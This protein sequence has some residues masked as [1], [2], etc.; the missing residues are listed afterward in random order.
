MFG[1]L[2]EKFQ[3]LFHSLAGKTTLTEDGIADAVKQVRLALL[4]ADVNYSVVSQF[5]KKVKE[6]CLGDS[7]LK[8]VKPGQYFTKIIHDELVA[9]MGNQEEPLLLKGS[10]AVI[11]LCGLQGS[12][13]TTQ[14]AK[15]GRYLLEQNK[16]R[17]IMLAACD[18]QRPAAVLQLKKLGEQIGIPV[19]ALEGE[20]DPVKV[21]VKALDEAKQEGFDILIL[22]TAGRLH[23]D[24]ELMEQ[25]QKIKAKTNPC[26]ILFVASCHTGQDAVKTAQEFDQKVSLTGTILTMLDGSA[27]AGAAI[28]IREITGKPLKFEGV[29]EKDLQL[30]NP[31]SMA[32]RILGMGDIIN[33]VRK[34]QEHFNEQEQ[35]ELEKKMMKA[36]FTFGDYLKSMKMMKKMGSFKSILQMIPGMPALD[37]MQVDEKE[38][39]RTEAIVLSMTPSER[40][41]KVELSHSRRKRIAKGCG[42]DVESVNRFVNKFTKMKQFFKDM[43]ALQ[44]QMQKGMGNKEKFLWR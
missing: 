30:F 28:S 32:D 34:S 13:K 25:L 43:P 15:L 23:V 31:H 44:K 8:S 41:G 29:G 42:M 9:L 12:G 38:I 26:E 17:K 11:M 40:E 5:I 2:T 33:L 36:S 27:R 4:D 35:E 6:K 14:C 21:A 18:L 3:N 7:V 19:F 39:H 24:E 16:Q 22:D 20:S 37:Q 10:P 1:T